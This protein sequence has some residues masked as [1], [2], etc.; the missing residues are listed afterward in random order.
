MNI[1]TEI[2]RTDCHLFYSPIR[3]LLRPFFVIIC[4]LIIQLLSTLCMAEKIPVTASIYPIAD[5]VQ[6]VGGDYVDVTFVIPAGASPHTFEPKPS[7]VKKFSSARIFFMVGAGLEFWAE[8]FV[9]LAGPGLTTV[10]LSDGVSLIHTVENRHEHEAEHHLE[11]K[12]E[13]RQAESGISGRESKVANPHIWLNPLIAKSMVNKIT[14]VLCDADHPHIKYYE[15]RSRNFL[16]KIDQLD[17]LITDRVANFK[18]KKYVSFHA[19]WVYFARR[20]GLESAGVIEA[21]P[22]RNPTPIQIKNIVATIK[23]Y[24]I[25]AVF[26]EPQLNPRAAEVIAREAEVNVLL[27]DPLGGPNLKGRNTY[28]DLMKYNLNV[29]Q[30]AMK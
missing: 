15:Q 18:I 8:K 26:A 22:G 27:L 14:A 7:L 30:E 13:H 21:A 16:E 4:F 1:H 5:M 6:Q 11:K 2:C 20:Y 10:V 29:M 19:S 23:K 3:T 12:T 17:R 9:S 28:I 24:H 25:R